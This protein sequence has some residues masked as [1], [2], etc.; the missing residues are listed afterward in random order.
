MATTTNAVLLTCR[1]CSVRFDGVRFQVTPC[2]SCDNLN[3]IE[4]P[5][6]PPAP[7]VEPEAQGDHEA[8]TRAVRAVAEAVDALKAACVDGP[9]T[10]RRC[11]TRALI[12]VGTAQGAL[13]SLRV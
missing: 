11:L 3:V 7:T 4:S 8:V 12:D 9:P 2:P 5:P 6:A 1:S 13:T 10:A